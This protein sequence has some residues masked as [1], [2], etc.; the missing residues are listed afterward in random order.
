MPWSQPGGG[1]G[2]IG[3]AKL[4]V[5]KIFSLGNLSLNA[6]GRRAAA[7]MSMGFPPPENL[8]LE[9]YL[10]LHICCIHGDKFLFCANV[11]KCAKLILRP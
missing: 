9:K 3:R 2:P 10:Y 4:V 7:N 6:I 5:R 1:I 8:Q 11:Y